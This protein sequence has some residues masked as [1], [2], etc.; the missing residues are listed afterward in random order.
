M[1]KRYRIAAVIVAFFCGLW[2]S[3]ARAQQAGDAQLV[4]RLERAARLI[5]ERDLARAEAELNEI[6][7]LKP[8]D[9]QALNFL[10]VIRAEQNR[11]D[12]AEK[13][14]K[15]AL[16]I[17]P[18]LIGARLNLGLLYQTQ[19][20]LDDAAAEFEAALKLDDGRREI[21]AS[22][23]AVLR[24]AAAGAVKAGE[25][26]KALSYLLRA[27][28]A[29]A[30][31][32]DVLFEFGMVA[33][34]LSLNEDAAQSLT[35][36]AKKRPDEPKFI[37]ALA[38]AKLAQSALDEALAL[39]N[40]Y[41]ALRP[42][43]AAGHYGLGYTLTLLRRAAEAAP[44]FK[45]SIELR[46]EQTESPYQLGL[47]A[48][49]DGD[50]DEAAAWFER[51]LSR[52][53]DHAGALMGLGL[54]QFKRKDYD[55]ARKSLERAITLD[56]SLAKAHYQLGLVHARLGDKEAAAREMET[57]AR[58]EREQKDQRRVALRLLEKL[59]SE[60]QSPNP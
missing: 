5:A 7:K 52:S 20:R 33:L 44:V 17:A 12:E 23:I 37:Y 31:D 60:P 48:Y 27:R 42:Q 26:E 51:V 1:S 15:D 30:T 50:A 4:A 9:P 34:G 43:D 16:G 56:P 13:L 47:I 40:R 24:R 6:Q 29:D 54:A 25:R 49:A 55:L 53:A 32:A 46:P 35:A 38:R 57:A 21:K 14:F 59:E 10:G 8:R 3:P 45:R 19:Q 18:R 11:A 58:L 39:F 41:V 28:A 22:L 36:A 2:G